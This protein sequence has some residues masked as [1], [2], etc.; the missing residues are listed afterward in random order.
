[1]IVERAL[2]EMSRDE[3][4]DGDRVRREAMRSNCVEWRVS[5]RFSRRSF[6]ALID[7]SASSLASAS[8]D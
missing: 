6:F 8:E 5:T 7:V 3:T 1:M 4:S 2:R